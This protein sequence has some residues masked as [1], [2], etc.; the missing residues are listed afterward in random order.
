M[1]PLRQNSLILHIKSKVKVKHSKPAPVLILSTDGDNPTCREGV[2]L[3]LHR[4]YQFPFG[5]SVV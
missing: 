5:I 2:S 1:D 4:R 3:S